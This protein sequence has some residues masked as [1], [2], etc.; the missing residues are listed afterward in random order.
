MGRSYFWWRVCSSAAVVLMWLAGEVL[1]HKPWAVSMV[2]F[3]LGIV[4][5]AIAGR[6]KAPRPPEEFIALNLSSP[7]AKQNPL[8]EE[9]VSLRL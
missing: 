6:V 8:P 7:L 5:Y 9:F 2:M 1:I 4:F 3:L